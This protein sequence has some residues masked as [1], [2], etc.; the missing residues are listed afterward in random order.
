MYDTYINAISNFNLNDIIPIG[1]GLVIG[2]FLVSKFINYLIDKYYG[3]TFFSIIGFTISTIPALLKEGICFNKECVIG[4]FISVL[5][6][7]LTILI[8]KKAN[9]V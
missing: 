6:C 2:I 5:F 7:F 3:Y 8:F 9:S 1:I 4:V